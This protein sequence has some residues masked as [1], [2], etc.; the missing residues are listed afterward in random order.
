VA[1]YYARARSN[2][3]RVKSPGEFE[4]WVNN[5]PN[6]VFEREQQ[7]NMYVI[8]VNCPDGGGWP[9][10]RWLE[11]SEEE[12]D[13]DLERELGGFLFEGQVAILEEVGHEKLRYLHGSSVAVN[14]LGE[15]VSIN[16]ND[17]FQ[18]VA[19]QWPDAEPPTEATY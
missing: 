19:E 15:T 8:Y 16:L 1:N 13:I 18:K 11:D 5:L 6:V 14:H 7:E 10:S 12:E 4:D 17:I 2:R 9:C 3:F